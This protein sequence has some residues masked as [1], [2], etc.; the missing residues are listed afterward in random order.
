M[1]TQP[2]DFIPEDEVPD[3]IPDSAAEA[4]NYS[5][6][7]QPIPG[8]PAARFGSGLVH[9]A[10]RAAL[11]LINPM[12]W[13][14]TAKALTELGIASTNPVTG[15]PAAEKIAAGAK[16]LG[17]SAVG[18]EGPEAMG[19]VMGTGLVAAVPIGEIGAGAAKLAGAT[20]GSRAYNVKRALRVS[21]GSVAARDVEAM[22]PEIN[23]PVTASSSKLARSMKAAKEAAGAEVAA[24][25]SALP[26][27]DIPVANVT[28]RIEP[29]PG[30]WTMRNGVME[31]VPD[32]PQMASAY[33]SSTGRLEAAAGDAGTLSTDELIRLKRSAQEEA[34]LG[35][36]YT[37]ERSSVRAK[38]AEA[39]GSALRQELEAIPGPESE[40]FTKANRR[41][42]VAATAEAP[43]AAEVA[44]LSDLPIAS[45]GVEML[46][47]RAIPG[48]GF[49]RQALGGLAGGAILDS[50]LFHT[51]SAAL[52]RRVIDALQSGQPQLAADLLM[53]SAAAN[54]KLRRDAEQAL[55][56]QGEGVTAP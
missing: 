24:T 21:P 55:Q 28:G 35:R 25:E 45:R 17:R 18:L 32:N 29:P 37:S 7:N 13:A 2:P 3:F 6:P 51:A 50:T 48:S 36:A 19:E 34:D 9:G 33:R 27:T 1:A 12:E 44:R 8:H 56:L 41:F 46:L 54:Q 39:R 49:A 53:R 20:E 14:R 38:A 31:F 10:A 16:Q 43:I 5:T 40:A 22:A 30:Q 52:K 26:T 23:M 4:P 42:Q 11:G 15:I 47:G